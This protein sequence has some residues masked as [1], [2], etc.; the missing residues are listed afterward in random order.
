MDAEKLLARADFDPRV[1]DGAGAVQHTPGLSSFTLRTDRA[2][3][4]Y[5]WQRFLTSYILARPAEVLRVKGFLTLH[6]YPQR[7]LFQAV[8]DLFT[9]D[10]WDDAPGGSEL[11]FI[12]RG[13]DRQEFAPAFAAC[14][15]PGD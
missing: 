6:G 8:R 2:L 9:A 1:L 13:L 11:V 15:V 12:G 10:A 7:I 14:A 4:P 5:A 3:D